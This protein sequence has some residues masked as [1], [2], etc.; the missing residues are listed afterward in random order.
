MALTT[1]SHSFLLYCTVE[2]FTHLGHGPSSNSKPQ[3]LKGP[4]LGKKENSYAPVGPCFKGDMY[5]VLACTP[6]S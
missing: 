2:Q 5:S 1:G 6:I 4:L 3:T